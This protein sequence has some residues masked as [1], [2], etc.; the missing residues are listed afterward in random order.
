[1]ASPPEFRYHY[2]RGTSGDLQVLAA[3]LRD[4]AHP[5]ITEIVPSYET[6]MVEYRSARIS[7]AALQA[8]IAQAKRN[9]LTVSQERGRLV[10]VPVRYDG[11]DLPTVSERLGLPIEEIVRLHSAREYRVSA[12]GFTPGFP[13]L[14]AVDDRLRLPR[15]GIPHP[16][17]P[18][19]TVA[20]ADFQTGVYP[21][22]TPGGW[23][24]L[25]QAL[26]AVYDPQ[27]A[28]P[29]LI[30]PGD[31]VRFVPATGDAPP[32]PQPL[33]LLPSDPQYPA[34]QVEAPGLLDIMVDAGRFGLAHFG[35]ARSGPHDS[36]AA[37]A[38]NRLVGNPDDATLLEMH[39]HGPT[40]RVLAETVLASAGAGFRLLVNNHAVRPYVSVGV[41]PGD[42]VAV[43]FCGGQVAYLS[44]AGGLASERFAGSTSVDLNGLIGQPLRAGDVLGVVEL[45]SPWPGQTFTPHWWRPR[46][47]HIP[48]VPG[49]QFSV[50]AMEVLTNKPFRVES[51]NRMGIMLSGS[52]VPGGQIASEGNP[53]GAIQ[54]TTVGKPI[55][56]LQ[57][58]GTIGGY[59]KP[60]LIPVQYL[61]RIVRA[62]PGDLVQFVPSGRALSRPY[63]K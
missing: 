9:S 1:M 33:S 60:V 49:P 41:Q 13:F 16:S 6:I 46:V 23:H 30:H 26:T 43:E 51:G 18:A 15:R 63:L 61:H 28:D 37:S 44:A 35:L 24:L 22:G 57:D 10:E 54:I 53:I 8:L 36:I 38:A 25:G 52:A 27:R 3:H 56:L 29:F 42:E 47:A 62:N 7:F 5:G 12:L 14:S 31:R 39:V 40:F 4:L 2:I 48:V 20:M 17:V 32:A 50:E 45:R 19:N 34:L 21:S 59:H 11:T 55:V 58:R